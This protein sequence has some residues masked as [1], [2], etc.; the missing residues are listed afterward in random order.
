MV[1]V[2]SAPKRLG[3]LG[4]TFDPVHLGHLAVAQAALDSLALDQVLFVPSF[5]PPHKQQ[6]TIAPFSDRLAMLK[7]ALVDEPQF[8]CSDLEGE[9]Q[10]LSYTIDTLKELRQRLDPEVTL[11]F[12]MGFDAFVEMASWKCFQGI[13]NLADLVVINRP[14]AQQSSLAAAVQ[15]V[16]GLQNEVVHNQERCWQLAG[17]GHI[18]ELVMAQVPISSSAIRQALAR[19]GDVSAML[20]PQV[21]AYAMQH[22]LYGV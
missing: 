4:G 17:G 10:E 18:H 3:I 7:L 12:L 14:Q 19:G 21:A 15:D 16:F 1:M 9:R 8:D 11:F 5:K 2:K 20:L 6:Q 13:P 22:G